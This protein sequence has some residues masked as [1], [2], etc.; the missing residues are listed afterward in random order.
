[1]LAVLAL[2]FSEIGSAYPVAGG[3]ARISYYSH[4][5]IAGF[6]AGWAGWLQAVFIPPIEI[7][8]T[9]N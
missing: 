1:M 6:T 7:L 2:V 9:I 4:G 8:A 3:G 5:P